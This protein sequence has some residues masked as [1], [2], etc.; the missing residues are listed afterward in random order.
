MQVRTRRFIGCA[1]VIV[2][3]V[4]ISA[5]AG[6]AGYVRYDLEVPAQPGGYPEAGF[7]TSLAMQRGVLVAGLPLGLAQGMSEPNG[8]VHVYRRDATRWHLA[9]V[10][11]GDVE[12]RRFGSAV[13]IDEDWLA[14]GAPGNAIE[15]GA[16]YVF[17]HTDGEWALQ[18]RLDGPSLPDLPGFGKTL[19]MKGEW[20]FVGS[21]Q[22]D[23]AANPT[24]GHV[25][26]YRL[27]DGSWEYVEEVAL[28]SQYAHAGNRW[29][30][31]LGFNGSRLYA[32]TPGYRT[33]GR[34][35]AI[36]AFYP[37][38]FPT[39]QIWRVAMSILTSSP[40]QSYGSDLFMCGNAI[41]VASPGNPQAS[42]AVLGKAWI[43]SLTNGTPNPGMT[44]V[45][46]NGESN[47]G[48]ANAVACNH[49]RVVATHPSLRSVYVFKGADMSW[50][51]H[52]KLSLEPTDTS[53]FVG[54]VATWGGDVIVANPSFN[55][56]PP[57][58]GRLGVLHVYASDLVFSDLFD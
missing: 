4:S 37:S 11:T 2:A 19:A 20:L 9:D 46:A 33:D 21:E 38:P 51:Q 15:T 8:Y 22:S 5:F 43:Y 53:E 7:G 14:V 47:D 3:A 42:P 23:A 32:G 12:A 45:P 10:V 1:A 52:A 26:A 44:L 13:A 24:N 25:Y 28:G 40:D 55:P 6:D 35:G 41:T 17:H 54:K 49:G 56:G 36:H 48:F 31:A 50:S 30:T 16:V 34:G 27:V 57:G 18:Q 39:P 29:G 58:S